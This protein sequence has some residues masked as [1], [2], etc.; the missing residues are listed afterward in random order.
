MSATSSAS[1]GSSRVERQST[2]RRKMVPCGV[3][4]PCRAFMQHALPLFAAAESTLLE[5]RDAP[6]VDGVPF[7][8]I[9]VRMISFR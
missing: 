4:N 2:I 8:S 7:R 9:C 5:L 3:T 1:S 6:Q